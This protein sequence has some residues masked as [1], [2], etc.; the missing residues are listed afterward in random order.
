MWATFSNQL[1]VF[2]FTLVFMTLLVGKCRWLLGLV[3][4]DFW[5]SIS[6]L[7]TMFNILGPL[8]CMTNAM[9]EQTFV[10]Y[11]GITVFYAFLGNFTFT[12]VYSLIVGVIS[13]FPMQTAL[14][15]PYRMATYKRK[16]E[17]LLE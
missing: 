9:S 8:V 5:T 6:K 2:G 14:S 12:I 16:T 15:M 11:K 7:T 17:K 1:F 3:S 4:T 10:N 13:E